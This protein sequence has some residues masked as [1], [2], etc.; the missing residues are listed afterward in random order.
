MR[1]ELADL[2]AGDGHQLAAEHSKERGP[3]YH[4]QDGELRLGK[5]GPHAGELPCFDVDSR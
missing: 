1:G 4:V 3:Q 2:Q 5:N